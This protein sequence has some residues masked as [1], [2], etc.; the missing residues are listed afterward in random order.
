MNHRLTIHNPLFSAAEPESRREEALQAPC[1]RSEAFPEDLGLAAA[2]EPETV[3]PR[4]RRYVALA[5][6]LLAAPLGLALVGAMMALFGHP[7]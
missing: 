5:G 7:V 1:Y 2:F 4:Y 3:A 6:L